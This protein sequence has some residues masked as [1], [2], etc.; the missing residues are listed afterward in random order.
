MLYL[1]VLSVSIG[2][3][4]FYRT[5]LWDFIFFLPALILFGVGLHFLIDWLI[6]RYDN[7]NAVYLTARGHVTNSLC[8]IKL[9]NSKKLILK[10][11]LSK[12][13]YYLIPVIA[14]SFA[15]ILGFLF[16]FYHRET[17]ILFWLMAG[18]SLICLGFF[19]SI[20]IIKQ[21][22]SMGDSLVFEKDNHVLVLKLAM[23]QTSHIIPFTLID[24]ILVETV[25]EKKKLMSNFF[26]P[27]YQT[28]IQLNNGEKVLIDKGD[29]A[30]HIQIL[31]RKISSLLNVDIRDHAGI[32]LSFKKLIASETLIH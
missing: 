19:Y 30:H 23:Q 3:Y 28:L 1:S 8:S 29:S 7:K 2:L 24:K 6:K 4:F 20:I 14:T 10:S 13:Q 9:N 12:T 25:Y 21:F 11:N 26:K 15:F 27:C 31:T 5:L 22:G 17:G 32:G 18:I 16:L